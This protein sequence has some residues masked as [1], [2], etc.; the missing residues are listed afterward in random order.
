VDYRRG[1]HHVTADQPARAGN[2][3]CVRF[4][5]LSKCQ[6]KTPNTKTPS[7]R[8]APNFKEETI[9]TSD[10]HPSHLQLT[11]AAQPAFGICGLEFLWSL[12]FGVFR[13]QPN[14]SSSW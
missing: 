3:Q 2:P 10:L 1:P 8:K 9:E 14:R 7:S 12:V 11:G 5:H 4:V 13:R 6:I